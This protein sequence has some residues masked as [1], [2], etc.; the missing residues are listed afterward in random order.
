MYESGRLEGFLGANSAGVHATVVEGYNVAVFG[1]HV[2]VD[3][4]FL[5][6]TRI[7]IIR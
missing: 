1:S 2:L 7:L 3:G 6:L 5:I 4:N